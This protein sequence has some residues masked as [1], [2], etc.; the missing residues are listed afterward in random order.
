MGEAFESIMRGLV[1]VKAHREGKLKLKTTTIEIAPIPQCDAKM[2]KTLRME[3]CLSQAA[4]AD[5][6]CVSKK[7]VEAWESGRNSPSGAACRLLD[8]IWK[9]KALL[10]REKIVVYRSP[11]IKARA[12][13]AQLLKVALA[14]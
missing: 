12:S 2:I 6:L 11:S 3:L 5:V 8:V 13:K 9:D 10:K 1:E 7:T 14:R 4:F